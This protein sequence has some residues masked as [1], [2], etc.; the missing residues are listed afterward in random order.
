MRGKRTAARGAKQS[1]I[2]SKGARATLEHNWSGGPLS[3]PQ[4]WLWASLAT[5]KVRACY[6]IAMI[7]SS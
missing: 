1:S 7:S 3:A 2:A 4:V 6:E 5:S